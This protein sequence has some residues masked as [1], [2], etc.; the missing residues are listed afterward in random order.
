MEVSQISKIKK[1]TIQVGKNYWDLESAGKVR[2]AFCYQKKFWPFTV[3]MNCSSDLKILTNSW[4][5]ASNFKSFSWS[6]KQFF[7]TVRMS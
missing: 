6:L 4:P 3:S 2:K 5:S 7:L 1:I